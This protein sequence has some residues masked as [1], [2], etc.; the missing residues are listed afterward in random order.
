MQVCRRESGNQGSIG[1]SRH[2][3]EPD[4]ADVALVEAVFAGG[5]DHASVQV[6]IGMHGVDI[7]EVRAPIG[8][9]GHELRRAVGGEHDR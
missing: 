9:I 4:Q 5:I 1:R 3:F 2:R 8:H 6:P 7:D